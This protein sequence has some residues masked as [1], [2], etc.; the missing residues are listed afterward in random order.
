[1]QHICPCLKCREHIK[2]VVEAHLESVYSSEESTNDTE[3]EEQKNPWSARQQKS[4]NSSTMT[5]TRPSGE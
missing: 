5:M 3:E 4:L 1:M 2:V